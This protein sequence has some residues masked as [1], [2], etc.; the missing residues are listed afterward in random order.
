[1]EAGRKALQKIEWS[2]RYSYTC[3]Y[4]WMLLHLIKTWLKTVS[5]QAIEGEHILVRK[6]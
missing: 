2:A 6:A 4:A 5:N 3:L 1:M